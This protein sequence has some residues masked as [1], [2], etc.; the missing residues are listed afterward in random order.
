LIIGDYH[1]NPDLLQSID[2]TDESSEFTEISQRL[3]K[4]QDISYL[5]IK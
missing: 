5:S 2:M 1:Q 3:P 4:K